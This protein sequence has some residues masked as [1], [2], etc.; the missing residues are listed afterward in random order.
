MAV[1]DDGDFSSDRRTLASLAHAPVK[2]ALA[3][4]FAMILLIAAAPAGAEESFDLAEKV[5]REHA[6]LTPKQIECMTL[7]ERDDSTALIAKFG[8]YERHDKNCGG[9]PEI[10][11]RLFDLEIERKTGT[12]KWDKNLPD[13]E[14]RPV[15]NRKN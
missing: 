15:P 14:M 5:I 3:T 7:V 8:I 2:R 9:D 13:M 4:S 1:T 12:A 6:L 11:H 10:F